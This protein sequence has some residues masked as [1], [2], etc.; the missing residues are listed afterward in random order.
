[1]Q[2]HAAIIHG[3]DLKLSLAFKLFAGVCMCG[4]VVF[5]KSAECTHAIAPTHRPGTLARHYA[6]LGVRDVVLMGKPSPII[7]N[8]CQEALQLQAHEVLAG[9]VVQQ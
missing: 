6:S 8:A 2:L 3:T 5:S 1:M 4:C 7:Y 9:E